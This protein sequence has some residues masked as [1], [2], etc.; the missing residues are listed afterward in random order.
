MGSK[1]MLEA[2]VLTIDLKTVHD[3]GGCPRWP[4]VFEFMKE[5]KAN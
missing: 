1:H 3:M 2:L 4:T 5:K